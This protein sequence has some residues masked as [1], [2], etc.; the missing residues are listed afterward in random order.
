MILEQPIDRLDQFA[1][2][3]VWGEK[4]AGKDIPGTT[5]VPIA[6]L[7]N[8]FADKFS[9]LVGLDLGSGSGRSTR[10]IT[11]QLPGSKIFAIDL[12]F[13]GLRNTLATPHRFQASAL[14]IPFRNET[15]DFVSVCGVF[16]NLVSDDAPQAIGLRV[17]AVQELYRT[18]KPGGCVVISDFGA[19]HAIDEYRVDYRRH[20]LITGEIGTIAVLRKGV[21][22]VGKTDKE[23]I[24][25]KGTD[26]VVRYAHHYFPQELKKLLESSGFTT[27]SITI[28]LTK[29]PSGIP[30]ENIVILASK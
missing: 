10:D 18:I 13:D 24:A 3:K 9:D 29:T 7:T 28:G 12:S 4:I 26:D 21:G 15:F 19:E 30:I 1:G 23:I 14:E 6:E 5:R 22:F 8:Y 20:A 25:M 17:R 2:L 11:E 27:N 16:T